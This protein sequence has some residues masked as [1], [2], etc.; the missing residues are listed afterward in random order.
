MI[1]ALWKI[2][3]MRSH[4]DQFYSLYCGDT[5]VQNNDGGMKF[6]HMFL[7]WYLT[8][9]IQPKFLIE[10]GVWK[11]LG[12][13]FLEQASPDTKI[14]SID[15]FPINRIYTS[16]KVQYL[17]EDFATIDFAKLGVDVDNTL[18]FVD[19]HQNALDRLVQAKSKGFKRMIFEDNYPAD[20]G[21][22]Y[23]IKKIL[24]GKLF[25]MDMGG[26]VSHHHPN[27][28]DKVFVENTLSV[29]QEM[30]PIHKT[31]YTRWKTIWD[32]YETPDS[33]LTEAELLKYPKIQ[34]ELQDYTWL[35]Y[36]E[37]CQHNNGVECGI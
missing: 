8:K 11:G 12:T 25:C 2:E 26:R 29:Y 28:Q 36:I 22:C 13:W 9:K 34:S 6:P 14:I 16:N 27:P 17:T 18:V 4:M 20:Q 21:D 10:S 31:K 7:A 33:I 1:D 37:L 23:S 3:D 24:S 19:D 30:P 15:P 35:C 5:P 32:N